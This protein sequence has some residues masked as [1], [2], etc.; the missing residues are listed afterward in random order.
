VET[1]K[2]KTRVA[3]HRMALLRLDVRVALYR[4]ELPRW[5]TKVALIEWHR[6]MGSKGGSIEK[7]C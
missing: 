3:L 7:R 5:E 1:R 4:M 2:W 6:L